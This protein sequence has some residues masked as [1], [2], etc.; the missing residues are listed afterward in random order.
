MSLPDKRS[1]V[2]FRRGGTPFSLETMESAAEFGL[3]NDRLDTALPYGAQIEL[4][5]G[6][7]L[8]LIAHVRELESTIKTLHSGAVQETTL[9]VED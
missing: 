4:L 1:C 8:D 7:V 5:S 3:A 6:W 9:A 2:G